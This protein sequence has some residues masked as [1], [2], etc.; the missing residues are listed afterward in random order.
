[1][2]PTL[3]RVRTLPLLT[4]TGLLI[5]G[6]WGA[7]SQF[8]FAQPAIAGSVTDASG[9]AVP[10]VTIEAASPALIE[11]T[12]TTITDPSGRYRIEHLRPGTYEVR[13]SLPGWRTHEVSGIELT[14]SRTVRADAVLALGRLTSDVVV[15]ARA[16][17]VRGTQREV[18]LT[19]ETVGALPT[20]RTYNALLAL[21]PGVVTS[22]N[23]VVMEA[24]TTSF[25]IH[26]GRATEGRLVLDGLTIGSPPSGNSGTSYATQVPYAQE[27]IFTTSSVSGETETGGL[28]MQLIPQS[29][30]NT[31]RGSLFASGSGMR[32]QGDNLT[33]ALEEQGIRASPFSKVY[34]VSAMLGGP[35]V[36][37]RVWYFVSGHSGGS[38]KQSTNVHYNLNAGD[39]SRWLYAP[40][41]E[42]RAYSDRTFESLNAR[43]TWQADRRNRLGVF[44]DAQALC[45]RCTGATPGLSEP[46]RV[47]PEA[48]GVLGRRLDVVQATWSS[49]VKNTMLVDAAFGSTFFGVGNFERRPNPTRSLIRVIEQ[50][51]RGC[52]ANGNIPGLTYRSQDFSDAHTG[53]YSWKAATAFVTGTR[54]LK[55]GYQHT[56]MIDDRTWMTNDQNLTYWFNDGVPD[57]LTQSISP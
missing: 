25:P 15:F 54:S 10:G 8:A 5:L 57:R 27:V 13:F 3:A 4:R 49:A 7:G 40:D 31:T 56:V 34:D 18:S 21:V 30:G 19:G 16:I 2:R 51:G 55:V 46:Q 28:V 1:M 6:S 47:S 29:G 38:R 32:F 42:R 50:C 41:L 35:I 14:G 44:W 43:L 36:R 17:D 26:G 24:A 23:D 11:K 12:R 53:S 22:T 33:P 39:P 48:V 37:N 52:P 45:R 9:G 20:A